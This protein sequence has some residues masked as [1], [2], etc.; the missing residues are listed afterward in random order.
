M[1]LVVSAEF[2]KNHHAAPRR[3]DTNTFAA[4][5]DHFVQCLVPAD[6][7]QQ[8]AVSIQAQRCANVT[9]AD[10]LVNYQHLFSSMRQR[11]RQADHRCRFACGRAA[12]CDRNDAHE[13]RHQ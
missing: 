10:V 7:I 12:R 1:R 2:F 3:K 13:I 5:N 4:G 8:I 6:H 11:C 9:G